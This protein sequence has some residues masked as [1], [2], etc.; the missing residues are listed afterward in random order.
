MDITEEHST[1]TEEVDCSDVLHRNYR[2][3]FSLDHQTDGVMKLLEEFDSKC[4]AARAYG[5]RTDSDFPRDT[6]SSSWLV[7]GRKLAKWRCPLRGGGIQNGKWEKKYQ[8]IQ[9]H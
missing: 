2:A 4:R 7:A 5:E 3:V 6:F 1:V 8:L 9:L